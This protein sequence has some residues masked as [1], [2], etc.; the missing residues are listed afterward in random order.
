MLQI[1][2]YIFSLTKSATR[3]TPIP[4]ELLVFIAHF[5]QNNKT[6]IITQHMWE[7]KLPVCSK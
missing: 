4:F 2:V 7:E 1:A 3:P 6:T 5:Q